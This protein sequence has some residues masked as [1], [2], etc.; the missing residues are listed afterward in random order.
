MNPTRKLAGLALSPD[1]DA[2]RVCMVAGERS[3]TRRQVRNEVARAQAELL[4]RGLVPGRRVLALLDHGPEAV[5]FLAAASSLGLHLLMPYGLQAAALS[6]WLS[7]ADAAEPDAVVHFK[8]DRAGLDVLRE[9]C[10]TVVELPFPTGEAPEAEVTV[11]HPEPVEHFL[12]LFTSGT[13]GKPKAISIGEAHICARIG[14]VTRTMGYGPTARIFM[15]GLMN[16]TTGVINSFGALLHDGTVVFPETPDPGQWPAQVARHRATHLALRPVALKRFVSAAGTGGDDLSCLRVVSYGGAAVPRTVLEQGREL[17]R[18]DWIQGYG[19]TETYGPFCFLDEQG[20]ADGHHLKHVYCIGRPDDS[21][22]VRLEPV[23]GHPDGV[24]EILVRGDSV[25]EG[26]V[27]VASGVV[28]PV[29]EWL[30][31]GDLAEWSPD[32][33]LVLKGRLA[34]VLLSENGHRIYPEEVEAV[35]AGTPGADEVVLAGL[36]NPNGPHELPVA[37]LCGPIG[38]HGAEELRA[39]V[40]AELRGSLAPEKWPDRIWATPE[41]FA[42]SANGKIMRGEVAAGVDPARVVLLRGGSDG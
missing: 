8:R 21:L 33:D 28:Q 22:E 5:F 31:T 3:L 20:H 4:E 2:D 19:L 18:C 17:V 16:N 12:V 1:A 27:D 23:A 38:L 26:Y 41:P 10:A 9:R 13:T 29:G 40:T 37:C 35:L 11:L 30:R 7:I 34:G 36:P 39:L 42:R 6:E 32:G 24:G 14:W 25:M 15:T